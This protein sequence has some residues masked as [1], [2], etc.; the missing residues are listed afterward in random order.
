MCRSSW[1]KKK[2][3]L[4]GLI[5]S[6]SVNHE[7]DSLNSFSVRHDVFKQQF[8]PSAIGMHEHESTRCKRC[9]TNK[10]LET[11]SMQKHLSKHGP[12][13]FK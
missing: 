12:K 1:K 10:S 3:I 5:G 7:G 13:P 11:I 6:D 8:T 4:Q 2:K 9:G